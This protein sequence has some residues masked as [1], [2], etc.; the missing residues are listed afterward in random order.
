METYGK[1]YLRVFKMIKKQFT[2]KGKSRT[3]IDRMAQL[4]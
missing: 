1:M 4:L 2:D 3:F